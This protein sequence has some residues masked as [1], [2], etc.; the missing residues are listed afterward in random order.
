MP[1]IN[2][3]RPADLKRRAKIVNKNYNNTLTYF[4]LLIIVASD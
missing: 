4:V 3:S 1:T 2:L